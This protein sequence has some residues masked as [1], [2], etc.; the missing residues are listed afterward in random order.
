MASANAS[1]IGMEESRAYGRR[2]AV[3]K[4]NA[5]VGDTRAGNAAEACGTSAGSF[6]FRS[7]KIGFHFI[8]RFFE[9]VQLL[10]S[11]DGVFRA[12]S[13]HGREKDL[14]Q[15]R[16]VPRTGF[17]SDEGKAERGCG[18]PGLYTLQA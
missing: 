12:A 14:N 8:V 15:G 3:D 13:R 11:W 6:Q 7:F 2:D 17:K 5:Y 1:P 10:Q 9:F 18:W 16:E 4:G